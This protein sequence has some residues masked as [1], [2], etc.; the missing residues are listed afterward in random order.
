M[1]KREQM[2]T[3]AGEAM[4]RSQEKKKKREEEEREEKKKRAEVTY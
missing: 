1:E 4:I 3:S 2:K